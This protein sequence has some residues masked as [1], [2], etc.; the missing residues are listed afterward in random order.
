MGALQG[1]PVPPSSG[2]ATPSPTPPTTPNPKPMPMPIAPPFD[3]G[4]ISSPGSL[5]VPD[6]SIAAPDGI[7]IATPKTSDPDPFLK[8]FTRVA[9]P[10][11]NKIPW[12][13]PG[14]HVRP[15][16]QGGTATAPEMPAPATPR[17]AE[18]AAFV[19]KRR[20]VANVRRMMEDSQKPAPRS[21]PAPKPVGTE[22]DYAH[23]FAKTPVTPRHEVDALL[24]DKPVENLSATEIQK[25]MTSPGYFKPGDPDNGNIRPKVDTWF[26]DTFPGQTDLSG[27]QKAEGRA[28]SSPEAR[29]E[30]DA[31]INKGWGKRPEATKRT[32]PHREGEGRA[33]NLPY[34]PETD[35]A[36][37]YNA[38]GNP[39]SG[40]PGDA[41]PRFEKPARKSE[42]ELGVPQGPDEFDVATQG[43]AP[44]HGNVNKFEESGKEI[45]WNE[46]PDAQLDS[47]HMDLD[48][49]GPI[50]ID[51][52]T[53]TPGLDGKRYH[54]DWQPLDEH[55]NVEP[56]W[57]ISSDKRIASGGHVT[58][59]TPVE[60]TFNP[61]YY[62]PNGFRVRIHIPPQESVHGNSSG[63]WLNVRTPKGQTAK[64]VQE[65]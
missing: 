33:R 46:K 13:N 9:P 3:F 43:M 2:A 41:V 55:G 58:P 16:T 30:V 6:G 52:N 45:E 60:R 36:R 39:G 28:F 59:I 47:G 31:H 25:L 48:V 56:S 23:D 21:R 18:Q 27:G 5:V 62:H 51:M 34:D 54:V 65:K 53:V 24:N 17:A 64:R 1:T 20:E 42:A 32:L 10:P 35:T 40:G 44:D 15:A 38:I 50:R 12:N 26:R 61:P 49:K 19:A 63:V 57:K 11:A 29:R 7:M 8:D 37:A 14:K 22:A 4:S